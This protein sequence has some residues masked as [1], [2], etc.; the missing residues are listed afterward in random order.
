MFID[1]SSFVGSF[2]CKDLSVIPYR[3]ILSLVY[4]VAR[5]VMLGTFCWSIGN[6]VTVRKMH[7][8]KIFKILML[9]YSH[10]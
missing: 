10:L 8:K 6:R 3:I 9:V 5:R 1:C 7:G 4:M 2:R